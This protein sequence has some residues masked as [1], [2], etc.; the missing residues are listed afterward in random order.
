MTQLVHHKY[1]DNVVNLA[2]VDY[3]NLS[4]TT[5]GGCTINFIKLVV[6]GDHINHVPISSWNFSE[7]VEGEKIIYDLVKTY[8]VAYPSSIDTFIEK[9][10]T[11]DP[12]K[13]H[14]QKDH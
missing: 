11:P 10:Q 6:V 4:R 14:I 1:Q 8:G 7:A 12:L 13:G 9:L 2:Q 3:I 5:D